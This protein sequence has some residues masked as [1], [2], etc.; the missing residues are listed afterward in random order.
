MDMNVL[1]LFGK[2]AA[3]P[4]LRTFESGSSLVRSLVTVRT[5]TPRRRVDVVP[6]VL[7]E[8]DPAHPLLVAPA[9]TKVF[10]VCSVQRRFWTVGEERQSRIELVA[11]HI[12]L[13]DAAEDVAGVPARVTAEST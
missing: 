4:E 8:P 13:E 10:A 2:L 9:G 1:V 12:E 3:P 5:A 6:V 7:W 11:R